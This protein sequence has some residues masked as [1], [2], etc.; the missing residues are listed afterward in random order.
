AALPGP[1]LARIAGALATV[2]ADALTRDWVEDAIARAPEDATCLV[3]RALLRSYAGDFVGAGADLERVIASPADPAIAHWLLARL[4]RQRPDANHV[5]RLRARIEGA[6]A[7]DREYLQFALFKELDDIG[8][9]DGAWAALDE[10]CRLVRARAPYDRAAHERLFAAIARTF[11]LD[12][13]SAAVRAD[14]PQPIF[15]VGMHRCGSTLL[16]SMLATHDAVYCYGE[17]QRLSGALRHAADH[18][19]TALLDEALVEA[20]PRLDPALVR[21]RFP[22]AGRHLVGDARF[23]TEKAPGSFQLVGFIR[24]ALPAAKIV[25]LRREAV[26]L[27]FANL[28]ELFGDGVAHAYAQDDLAHYHGLYTGLMAHW[29]RVHPGFVLDVDYEDLVR[30]PL[31]TSQRVFEFCGLDWH[32]RVVEPEAW[33]SRSINT[34]SS[35]QARQPVNRSSVGRWKRYADRLQPLRDAL[36]R[37]PAG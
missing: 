17:S 19:C 14:A 12:G 7:A 20:A 16:E 32:P 29:H 15:I 11:P 37:A 23:V 24:Q 13:P 2:G 34:L 28:R 21:D 8:D 4:S 26:D 10:G 27:C 30:D 18:A 35:V 6:D 36:T 5:E 33:A 22:D 31:G 25:H 1:D 9:L 3:N